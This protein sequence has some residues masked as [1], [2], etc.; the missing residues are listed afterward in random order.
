MADNNGYTALLG[1]L[2]DVIAGCVTADRH[3]ALLV[4]DMSGIEKLVPVLGYRKT[5]QIMDSVQTQLLEI[6]RPVDICTR[7]GTNRF[8]LI[9]TDLQFA[10]MVDLLVNKVHNT[11][12]GLRSKTGMEITICPR[13]GVAL[14]PEHGRTPEG[15]LIA[16]DTAAQAACTTG[17]AVV[18]AGSP[19]YDRM[20]LGKRL[21]A[22]LETAFLQ[23]GF[24]LHYQPKIALAS[25]QLY[26]AEALIRWDHPQYGQISPDLLVPVIEKSHLLQ[27]ITLWILN[28]ALHQSCLMRKRVPGFRIAVNL[29]PAILCSPD[30]VALVE[31]AL[32]IW[33]TEPQLLTLEITE[34]TMM[35][36]Q[37]FSQQNLQRLSE[38]GVLLSIDDFGTGYSSYAYLQ[39]L[40]VQE[41][42]IDKSFIT[43]LTS[44]NNNDRLVRSIIDLGRGLGLDVLAE[45]IESPEVLERLVD[46]GCEYGQGFLIAHPMSLPALLE[47]MDAPERRQPV[48]GKG[49]LTRRHSR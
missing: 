49:G 4:I 30:L 33:D 40:F 3:M 48:V 22:E 44:D 7:I 9:V 27:E 25:R 21:E 12:D 17:T 23:S 14:Y 46:M 15:L 10:A 2:E 18:Q 28:T 45:G 5:G 13:F 19:E 20:Y 24:E 38:M 34:S 36:N 26:G 29:S 8:A 43:Q 16:A 32:R 42:K 11:L 39:Q 1:T 47:W 31:R 6:K 41:L 37:E 35:E